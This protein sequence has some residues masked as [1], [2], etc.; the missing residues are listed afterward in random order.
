MK[1]NKT[2]PKLALVL[3]ILISV[4][5]LIGFSFH[6]HED[7]SAGANHDCA[8]CRFIKVFAA[9][10]IF[11]LA[12]LFFVR[13]NSECYF[14]PSFKPLSFLGNPLFLNRA[15]PVLLSI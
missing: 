7:S 3:F 11:I 9:L 1:L 10:T 2:F 12:V 13:K 5:A 4:A 15:P 14:I 8:V 6:H